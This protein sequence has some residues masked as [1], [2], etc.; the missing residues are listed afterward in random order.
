MDLILETGPDYFYELK[1]SDAERLFE[2]DRN[3]KCINTFGTKP[4]TD[5]SEV[6]NI[7]NPV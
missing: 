3:L 1:L 5:I 2:M 4:L 7:I 6:N